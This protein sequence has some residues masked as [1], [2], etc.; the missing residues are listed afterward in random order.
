[1]LFIGFAGVWC[2]SACSLWFALIL[3]AV[4]YAALLGRGFLFLGSP[5]LRLCKFRLFLLSN[6]LLRTVCLILFFQV[7]SFCSPLGN[8]RSPRFLL[9]LVQIYMYLIRMYA[10]F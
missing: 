5:F 3:I 4:S 9:Q 6:T 2:T 10:D 1:M 8:M 7:V